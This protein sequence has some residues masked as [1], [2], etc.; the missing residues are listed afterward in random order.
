MR[1]H[2]ENFEMYM[3]VPLEQYC[4]H[5]IE[6]IDREIEEL[7][8]R[9]LADLL[10]SPAGY[11][12]EVVNLHDNPGSQVDVI[13]YVEPA[14]ST[15]R[16]AFSLADP[17]IARLFFYPYVLSKPVLWAYLTVV[18]PTM[19]SFTEKGTSAERL[20][21]SNERICPGIVQAFGITC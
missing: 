21:K 7:G 5:M 17:P 1:T 15:F 18:E 10:L 13:P 14:K 3:D 12:L 6:A 11:G 20:P 9:A 4:T 16:G 2:K 19:I 8:I